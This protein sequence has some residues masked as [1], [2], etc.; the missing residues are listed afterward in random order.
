MKKK[1]LLKSHSFWS[2]TDC[3][4]PDA[5]ENL[6]HKLEVFPNKTVNPVCQ[7]LKYIL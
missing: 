1:N 3:C 2:L 6:I 5:T 4:T 7:Y